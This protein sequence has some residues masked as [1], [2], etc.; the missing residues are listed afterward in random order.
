MNECVI[1]PFSVYP[2][3]GP[4]ATFGHSHRWLAGDESSGANVPR[5]SG[6]STMK[7]EAGPYHPRMQCII[8]LIIMTCFFVFRGF[9]AS[10]MAFQF[11]VE[12]TDPPLLR[13]RGAAA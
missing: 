5:H 6:E 3:D 4:G 13:E 8:L 11:C 7:N 12:V 2:N 9:Q 1:T 10:T